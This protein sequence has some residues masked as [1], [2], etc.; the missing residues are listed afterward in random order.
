MA[1]FHLSACPAWRYRDQHGASTMSH[2]MS[3]VG[4]RQPIEARNLAEIKAAVKKHG[5]ALTAAYPDVSFSI[6]VS[7]APRERKP[8]GFDTAY[9]TNALGTEAWVQQRDRDGKPLSQDPTAVVPAAAT[10]AA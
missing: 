7:I 2:P 9:K 8:N 6:F 1:K 5:E 3:R 4:E 10:A